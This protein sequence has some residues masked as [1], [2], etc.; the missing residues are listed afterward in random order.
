MGVGKSLYGTLDHRKLRVAR[1]VVP[2]GEKPRPL[3]LG[4]LVDLAGHPK[5]PD[6]EP[7]ISG[8]TAASVRS[9]ERS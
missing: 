4:I 2:D 5:V 9:E 6:V 1:D 8:S 3:Y 7:L